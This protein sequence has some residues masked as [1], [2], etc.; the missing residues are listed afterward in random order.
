MGADPI[1]LALVIGSSV[2]SAASGVVGYMGAQQQAAGME[3]QA[4]QAQLLAANRAQ[5]QRNNA[6]GQMQDEQFQSGVA[7]FNKQE[8]LTETN[9]RADL[10]NQQQRALLASQQADMGRRGLAGASF[11]DILSAESL[12]LEQEEVDMLY[13]GGQQ[14]YQFGKSAELGDLRGR[15]SIEMGRYDSALSVTEGN[16]RSASLKNQASSARIGGIGTAIDGLGQA[17]GTMSSIDYS[18]G[19]GDWKVGT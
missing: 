9:R 1:S 14:S 17:A 3:Q 12:R 19:L 16:Y 11:E 13:Q 10:M 6:I 18:G 8:A 5:I 4:K 2:A 15:R 7:R